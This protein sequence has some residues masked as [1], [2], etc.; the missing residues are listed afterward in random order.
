MSGYYRDGDTVTRNNP[1][2]VGGVDGASAVQTLSVDDT[3][4]LVISGD[5]T[6]TA[7]SDTPS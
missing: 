2:L 4:A 1:V 3:G 7:T 5:V 6:T